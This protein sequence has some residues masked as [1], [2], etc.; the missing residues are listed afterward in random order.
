MRARII[1]KSSAARGRVMDS[2]LL[3]CCEPGSSFVERRST[4]QKIG[5]IWRIADVMGNAPHRGNMAA[6]YNI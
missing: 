3:L 1:A 2:S 4:I 6:R 5:L